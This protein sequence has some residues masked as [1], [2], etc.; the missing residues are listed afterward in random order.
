MA[1]RTRPV[2]MSCL[3]ALGASDGGDFERAAPDGIEDVDGHLEV[4]GRGRVDADVD[5][6]AAQAV[7]IAHGG[8]DQLCPP[9]RR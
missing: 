9:G 5:P 1:S 4:V 8:D 3:G 7:G 6:V 2:L